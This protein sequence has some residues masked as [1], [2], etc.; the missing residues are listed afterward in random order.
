MSTPAF[1]W[2]LDGTLLDSYEA[3]VA[4]ACKTFREF[5]IE[6][7]PKEVYQEAIRTSVNHLIDEVVPRIGLSFEVVKKR[8]SE[9][10]NEERLNITLIHNAKEILSWL[11]ENGAR[12][13]VFTHRG[14]STQEVLKNLDIFDYF[15]DIITGRD[16]FARK[17][18]PEAIDHLVEKHGLD[19]SHTYYVGDRTIDIDC[20]ANA[21]IRSI[22]YLPEGSFAKPNGKETFIVKDLLEIREIWGSLSIGSMDQRSFAYGMITAF[23]ECVAG[24]CKRLALS[25]PLTHELFLEVRDQACEIIEKHGLIWFHEENLDLPEPERF[26]WILIALRPETIERYQAL[27]AQGLNPARSLE[28]FAELLSYNAAESVHTGYDAWREIFGEARS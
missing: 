21:G 1:I 28:P 6:M 16:G 20:A 13:Y 17:P 19:R 3:I 18:D 27:R 25:P 2:D 23:C 9:I 7:D 26:E 10:N 12:N 5:G 4:S 8:Y 15:E 22:M 11:K 24:G 14:T